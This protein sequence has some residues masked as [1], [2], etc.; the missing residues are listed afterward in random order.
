MFLSNNLGMKHYLGGLFVLLFA[1]L[2][3][4][5]YEVKVTTIDVWVKV[6]DKSGQAVTGLKQSDFQLLEDG[7]P[8]QST[9]FE[10]SALPKEAT[11]AAA[12]APQQSLPELPAKKFVIFLDLYNTSQ[13]EFLYIRTKLLDFVKRFASSNRE[14]MLAGI[15]PDRNMG[16]FSPFTK[17][18][19]KIESLI[20]QAQGNAFRDRSLDNHETDLHRILTTGTAKGGL[21]EAVRSGYQMADSFAKEDAEVTKFSLNALQKFSSWLAKQ[22]Q[23]EHSIVLYVSGGF[24]VDPGRHYFDLVDHYVEDHREEI[25]SPELTIHRQ[26]INFDFR[27]TLEESIGRL[28]RLNIT[29]YTINTRGLIVSDPDISKTG[30]TRTAIDLQTAREYGD[31]LDVI[32]E[33][34][35]G[36]SFSNS[37]NFKLGFNNVVQDLDHQYLLCYNAPGHKEEGKYHKITVAVKGSDA[38]IRHRSGYLD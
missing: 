12:P 9:C 30:M 1:S 29:L 2:C 24:S 38:E 23:T 31:S 7:Q 33:E 5:Q 18:S 26:G 6:T 15:R 3:F 11:P 35:G 13:P 19:A 27:R 17:D 20:Q 4:A 36:I 32:A 16:V 28:N 8:V 22:S 21:E 25:E 34:T 14:I 37:Q 10:E